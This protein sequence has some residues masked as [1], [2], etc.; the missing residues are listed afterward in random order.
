MGWR[1]GMERHSCYGDNI[2]IE[3]LVSLPESL[4]ILDARG[5]NSTVM[6]NPYNINTYVYR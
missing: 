2:G 4:W 5:R 3:L 1:S 6:P